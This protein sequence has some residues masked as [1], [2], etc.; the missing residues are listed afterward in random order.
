MSGMEATVL[1]ALLAAAPCDHPSVPNTYDREI[2]GAV[3]QYWP[4]F[5]Q[6][7]WCWAKSQLWAESGLKAD[8]ESH[9]GAQGI[10]QVMPATWAEEA[11][12]VG[13]AYCSPFDAR[14]G[15]QVGVAY[16]GKLIQV[17]T[18]PRPMLDL[19]CWEAVSYNAGVGNALQAQV[20]GRTEV[21]E[22]GLHVLPQVTGKHAEETQSYVARIQRWLV[23][24]LSGV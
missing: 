12:R 16:M 14:C 5:A 2:Q 21:C 7:Y 8:A 4:L 15:I 19:L 10:A 22:E 24:L 11:R 9:A 13:V 23:R 18:S 1:V 6:P 3:R 20:E 17:Y